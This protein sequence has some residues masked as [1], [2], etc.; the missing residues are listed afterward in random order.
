MFVQ[1]SIIKPLTQDAKFIIP[2]KR[3]HLRALRSAFV[4]AIA[5]AFSAVDPGKVHAFNRAFFRSGMHVQFQ[6]WMPH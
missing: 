2:T 6:G 3:F 4:P 5:T 1:I